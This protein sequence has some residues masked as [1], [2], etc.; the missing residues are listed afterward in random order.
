MI[1]QFTEILAYLGRIGLSLGLGL[2]IGYER[3]GQDKPAGIRDVTLVTLGATLFSLISLELIKVG[4]TLQ[5]PIRYDLGR[6]IAYTI[7]SIGFLGSGVIV[8]NKNKL[9]G[10]TT[11]GT[12]WCA[13][14]IGIFC[15]LGL[16]HLAMVSAMAVYLI[17][18][19][20]HIRLIFESHQKMRKIC[21]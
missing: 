14:A 21:M 5:P 17:L 7:V 3:E 4:Q 18:K 10:I 12:L 16:Y 1:E 20:K 19:L 11:A 2:F 8:Q 13:V 15:G 9:E 6:V